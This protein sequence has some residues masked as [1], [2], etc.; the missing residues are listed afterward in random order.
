MIVKDQNENIVCVVQYFDEIENERRF[1]TEDNEEMQ[2]ASFKYKKNTEV[3]RHFHN[4]NERNISTTAEGIVVLEGS[5][6]IEIYDNSKNFLETIAL[7]EK[8]SI[9][10][11]DGGRKFIVLEDCKF[12]EFKQGP[13]DSEIDKTLF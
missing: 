1:L 8:D 7:N 12:I 13:Y 5:I 6:E 4:L 3:Q 9:L 2:Y 10:M 11:L